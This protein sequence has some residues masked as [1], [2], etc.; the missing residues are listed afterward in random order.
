MPD[1]TALRRTLEDDDILAVLGS[2]DDVSAG[3]LPDPSHEPEQGLELLFAVDLSRI[4]VEFN[5][6]LGKE[7]AVEEYTLHV[8]A[9]CAANFRAFLEHIYDVVWQRGLFPID[10]VEQRIIAGPEGVDHVLPYPDISVQ[11]VEIAPASIPLE[12]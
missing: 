2:H 4:Q 7:V 3:S 12:L 9:Q 10:V 11:D 6:V 1:R 5:L 8:Y